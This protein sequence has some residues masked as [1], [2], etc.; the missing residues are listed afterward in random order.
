MRGISFWK[1]EYMLRRNVESIH[2]MPFAGVGLHN[3]IDQ[4]V[5]TTH[6]AG[7][8]GRKVYAREEFAVHGI[9]VCTRQM[10]V[11][12]GASEHALAAGDVCLHCRGEWL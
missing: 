7:W 5:A 10:Y 8:R 1:A 12:G 6:A 11:H 4:G 9:R 2:F 3:V